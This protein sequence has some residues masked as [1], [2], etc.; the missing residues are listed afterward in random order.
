MKCGKV[1]IVDRIRAYDIA[2]S[3]VKNKEI[4]EVARC[5]LKPEGYHDLND[6][7]TDVF[8][9]HY[10][11]VKEMA[12]T[13]DY[14]KSATTVLLNEHRRSTLKI[15]LYEASGYTMLGLFAV[16]FSNVLSGELKKSFK[17]QPQ[18][19]VVDNE[20]SGQNPSTD[21][22][23]VLLME[24]CTKDSIPVVM[25]E[26]KPI[27]NPDPSRMDVSALIEMLLQ[28]HYCMRTHNLDTVLHCLTDL[29]SWYYYKIGFNKGTS[30]LS[31]KWWFKIEQEDVVSENQLEEHAKFLVGEV[32]EFVC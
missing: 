32:S 26:Y 30:N 23:I 31:L 6:F 25:Y 17:Y 12:L 19:E 13:N 24:S 20:K 28:A 29:K 4:L 14:N 10:T 15:T 3:K 2:P 9:D 1:A 8:K 27:V 5:I 21:T 16:Y 7:R 18:Y 11:A 22:C